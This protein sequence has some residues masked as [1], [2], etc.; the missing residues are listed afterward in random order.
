MGA[1]SPVERQQ[2][3]VSSAPAEFMM[4]FQEL[5]QRAAARGGVAEEPV[6]G[7]FLTIS[8]EACSG[9]AEVA[10]KVGERLSWPVLDREL[11]H[12]LAEQLGLEPRLLRLMDETRID[13][14]S[15]TLLNLF[16]FRLLYQDSFV[17]MLSRSMALAAFDRPVV[18]VGRAGNLVLSPRRGLRVRI[19]A[20]RELRLAALAEREKLDLRT[21]GRL[22]DRLDASRTEFVRRNFHC[23]PR[24]P[25][26]YD[27]IINVIGFG[28]DGVADLICRALEVRGFLGRHQDP[29]RTGLEYLRRDLAPA[30]DD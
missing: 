13:W 4:R 3:G 10:R 19:I 17:S 26:N 2:G 27:M 29:V 21:A 20:P 1:K 9:G 5:R 14:F 28:A 18:I 8:R 15:E 11:I 23:D 16:N 30:Y 22:L 24:D 25:E 7:P 12:S 6:L